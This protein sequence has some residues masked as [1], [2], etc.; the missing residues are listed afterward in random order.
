MYVTRFLI[1]GLIASKQR[2]PAHALN[3]IA[4]TCN[5][6]DEID[7]N[8]QE[9]GK[10]TAGKNGRGAGISVAGHDAQPDSRG[11]NNLVRHA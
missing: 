3:K 6:A 1:Y 9:S 8:F 2:I 7:F 4:K 11:G 5:L 10:D